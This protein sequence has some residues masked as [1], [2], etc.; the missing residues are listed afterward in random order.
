MVA[1]RWFSLT[2]PWYK[3]IGC[4]FSVGCKLQHE[5]IMKQMYRVAHKTERQREWILNLLSWDGQKIWLVGMLILLWVC[6]MGQCCTT[7]KT[8]SDVAQLCKQSFGQSRRLAFYSCCKGEK[9]VEA[10]AM[11]MAHE[12]FERIQVSLFSKLV[13]IVIALLT[14]RTNS[15]YTAV[16]MNT[17]MHS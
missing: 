1:S 15:G 14:L 5:N 4:Y 12:A 9:T 7:F 10:V 11:K 8:T 16:I 17:H 13:I 6:R 3:T 2:N